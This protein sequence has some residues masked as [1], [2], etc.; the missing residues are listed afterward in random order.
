MAKRWGKERWGKKR[1][2]KE[3]WGEVGTKYWFASANMLHVLQV[4]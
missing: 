2:G 4:R 3:R 1:W